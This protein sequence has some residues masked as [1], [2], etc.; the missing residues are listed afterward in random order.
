MILSDRDIGKLF[1][2]KL[3]RPMTYLGVVE[4][5][6]LFIF[7]DPPQDYLAFRPDQLWMLERVR[8]EAAPID[9]TKEGGSC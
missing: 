1:V 5:K 7:R 6:H 4:E 3:G 8:P 2:R 9:N